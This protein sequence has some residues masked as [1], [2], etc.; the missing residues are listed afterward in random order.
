M[1]G[2]DHDVIVAGGGLIGAVTALG[3]ARC[4]YRVLLVDRARPQLSRGGFG[5][6]IRNIAC[7]PG[8]QQVLEAAGVWSA[9]TPAPYRKMEVWEER[10][11]SVLS[12]RAE[13]SGRLELGWI[14]E[15]SPTVMAVWEMLEREPR[16]DIVLGE[17]DR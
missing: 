9:L 1:T 17:V 6:D 10:G 11:T 13:E 2:P 3:L 14:L 15:N 16:A 12:F 7:S 4:G 5:M 8:S